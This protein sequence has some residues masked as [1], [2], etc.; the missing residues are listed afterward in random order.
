MYFI[1]NLLGNI[2]LNMKLNNKFRNE[3]SNKYNS[4]FSNKYDNKYR[5]KYKNKGEL[6]IES[7]VS[8]FIISIVLIPISK[9]ICNSY[10]YIKKINMKIDSNM[11]NINLLEYLKSMEYEKLILF[12][13][14][15]KYE[16]IGEI[17]RDFEINNSYFFDSKNSIEICI[18]KIEYLNEIEKWI[19]SIRVGEYEEK[20][21]PK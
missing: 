5:N 3:Y 18:K 1:R 15:K 10:R 20:Y 2:T 17:I 7:L 16:N 11:N 13:G 9:N 4:K 21:I 19:L 14:N 12:E 8:L 6:L